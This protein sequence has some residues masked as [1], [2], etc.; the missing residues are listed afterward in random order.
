MSVV[1]PHAIEKAAE[2]MHGRLHV[3]F[4]DLEHDW[5]DCGENDRIIAR[6]AA[7]VALEAS[8]YPALLSEAQERAERA[9]AEVER[10]KALNGRL[11]NAAFV[12]P[13]GSATEFLP[14]PDD[15]AGFERPVW[16]G[17]CDCE[18]PPTCTRRLARK[19]P[20]PYAS[21]EKP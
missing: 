3:C 21:E 2:A 14:E 11:D 20:W 12:P 15:D 17:P 16:R 5:E 13:V 8:G 4:H 1:D 6:S 10:L 7:E 18:H 19:C 9:E